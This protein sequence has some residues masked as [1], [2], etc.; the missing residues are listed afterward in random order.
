[1]REQGLI[2]QPVVKVTAFESEQKMKNM[3]GGRVKK[4][5]G[6][7]GIG[8]GGHWVQQQQQ[9]CLKAPLKTAVLHYWLCICATILPQVEAVCCYNTQGS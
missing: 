3:G 8:S 7:R 1:M 5:V 4:R 9:L 2:I 6:G